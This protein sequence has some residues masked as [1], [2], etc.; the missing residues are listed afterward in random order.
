MRV[1]ALFRGQSAWQDRLAAA[2]EPLLSR[3]KRPSFDSNQP[4][5]ITITTPDLEVPKD[6]KFE[7]SDERQTAREWLMKIMSGMPEQ[8]DVEIFDIGLGMGRRQPVNPEDLMSTLNVFGRNAGSVKLEVK[9]DGVAFAPTKKQKLDDGVRKT[10]PDTRDADPNR[11]AAAKAAAL[12]AHPDSLDSQLEHFSKVSAASCSLE[13]RVDLR[14][15]RT[16]RLHR[17]LPPP[18][19]LHIYMSRPRRS[20]VERRTSFAWSSSAAVVVSARRSPWANIFS[21][22][23]S[24]GTSSRCQQLSRATCRCS[25]K[26]SARASAVKRAS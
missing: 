21:L 9:Y 4:R 12:Y 14:L 15:S 5:S 13:P 19:H 25:C 11:L 7:R 20:F 22:T 24:A 1:I 2:M 6:Y 8:G 16:L 3:E 17:P 10:F 18:P 26:W 23:S